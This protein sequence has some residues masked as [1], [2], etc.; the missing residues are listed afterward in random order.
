MGREG[1]SQFLGQRN[2]KILNSAL[3]II[4]QNP[5]TESP[6]IAEGKGEGEEKKKEEE[7][8]EGER[9]GWRKRRKGEGEGRVEEEEERGGGRVV[10]EGE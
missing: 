8:E 5:F 10:E 9:E 2:P 3:F 6:T 1:G 4:K 7:K